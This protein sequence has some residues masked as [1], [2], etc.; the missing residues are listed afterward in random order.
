VSNERL[1]VGLRVVADFDEVREGITLPR[2]RPA[3]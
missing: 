2:F 3:P 1:A